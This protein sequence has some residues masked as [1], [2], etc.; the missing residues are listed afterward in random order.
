MAG[1]LLY[2][3]LWFISGFSAVLNADTVPRKYLRGLRKRFVLSK[4][5]NIRLNSLAKIIP[6]LQIPFFAIQ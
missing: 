1:Q 6:I 3:V 4:N 2:N 5:R